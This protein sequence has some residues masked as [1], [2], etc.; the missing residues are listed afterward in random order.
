MKIK[1]KMSMFRI[2][3][4]QNY[5][6][7]Y[8]SDYAILAYVILRYISKNNVELVTT[9][10]RM[11]LSLSDKCPNKKDIK[12][13]KQGLEILLQNDIIYYNINKK[14]YMID[15]SDLQIDDSIDK[16]FFIDVDYIKKIL[17]QKNGIKLLRYYMILCSAINVFKKYGFRSQENLSK[18]TKISTSTIKRYNTLLKDL[19][20]IYFSKHQ[21]TVDKNGNFI[22]L[23]KLYTLP[24]YADIIDI[25]QE[26]IINKA[27]TKANKKKRVL[28]TVSCLNHI[29]EVSEENEN[30]F[31]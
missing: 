14:E 13:I 25:T 7:I 12:G 26:D 28:P 11:L 19:N 10:K 2:I 16:F 27:Q 23:P 24:E 4:E 3:K 1:F 5:T 6:N 21:N 31:E 22:N 9:P 20:V 15:T 30:P 29:Q 8:N 17:N 18:L